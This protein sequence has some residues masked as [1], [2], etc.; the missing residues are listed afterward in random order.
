MFN[1]FIA[2]LLR[3]IFNTTLVIVSLGISLLAAEWFVRTYIPCPDY[4]GGKRPVLYSNLFEYDELVGWKGVPNISS[5]YYSKDFRIHI[6]HDSLGYRNISPPYVDKK[7]N[8][9][10]L[11]DSYGWGWGVEDDETAA[12][13]FNKRNPESNIYSMGI[14][15]YGTDQEYLAMKK[16]LEE[17][18]EKKY[19]GAILLFYYNDFENNAAN[20]SY[21]YPKPFFGL[22]AG[23]NLSLQNIPVP[24]KYIAQDKPVSI[25][26]EQDDSMK[27]YHLFN[28]FTTGAFKIITAVNKAFYLHKDTTEIEISDW[29]RYNQLLTAAIIEDMKKYCATVNMEFHVVFLITQNTDAQPATRISELVKQLGQSNIPHSFFY[30]RTFP[31]TDLWLDTHYTPYGQALLASHISAVIAAKNDR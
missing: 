22:D 19:K 23:K 26:P 31:R 18:P 5:P 7:N 20:E 30:S 12:A 25:E 3:L 9:L 11:G 28:L 27:K 10:L 29:E 21:L 4:G 1:K 8:Y 2:L 16:F 24:K 15:G 6:S 13:V 14:P 17:N